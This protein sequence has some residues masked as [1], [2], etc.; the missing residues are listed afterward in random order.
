MQR[1]ARALTAAGA[2]TTAETIAQDVTL[3][4][5]VRQEPFQGQPATTRILGAVP[6][7]PR[8]DIEAGE[9]TGGH[10][11]AVPMF[12]TQAAGYRGRAGGLL[13]ACAGGTG[14]IPELTVFPRPLAAL[15]GETGRRPGG[16]RPDGRA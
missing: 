14:P 5:A 10:D 4:A 3:R 12:S 11:S 16:P 13:A 9:T 7:G 2:A 6:D 15:A 8:H 1:L